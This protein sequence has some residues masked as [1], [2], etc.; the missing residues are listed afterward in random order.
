MPYVIAVV[1][2]MLWLV[3]LMSSHTLGGSIHIL[4]FV[5]LVVIIL[6]RRRSN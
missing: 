6:G 5:A 3:G 1:L 4:L 2:L